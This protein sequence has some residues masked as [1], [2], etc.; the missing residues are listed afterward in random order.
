MRS[1]PH[2]CSSAQKYGSESKFLTL[3]GSEAK[4]RSV[5][6]RLPSRARRGRPAGGNPTKSAESTYHGAS[7]APT[8]TSSGRRGVEK[9]SAEEQNGVPLH[10]QKGVAGAQVWTGNLFDDQSELELRLVSVL[11]LVELRL[12]MS[13]G[14]SV[15]CG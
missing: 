4:F 2:C 13:C 10:N 11:R 9:S 7:I 5:T 15:R 14:W 8:C 6:A 1:S 3:Y 12:V